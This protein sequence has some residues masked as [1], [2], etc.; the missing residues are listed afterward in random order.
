MTAIGADVAE[1]SLA[2]PDGRTLVLGWA[3][4]TDRGL[5]RAHNEDSVLAAVPYFAVADGMGGHA[6]GDVASDAVIRRLAEEQ[7]R[8][9]S[10]FADPEGVEPALDLAVGDIR[11]ETG[12]LEL[13]AGT[14]VT[15]ACLTLVSDRPYWAVFNVGDSRVYQLRGD[16]L[17]QVTVDHSVVQEMVDAGRITR[18]QADRHPDG[19]IITRAVGVGDAAEADYWLLPVT[20]RLRLLVCSDGLTKELADAEIRGHLLRADDAATAVRDLVVH[21]LEN[22]GRDNV[23]AVVVDV[24]RIDP[25]A[26]TPEPARRR[27]LRR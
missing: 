7:E 4:M 23:T 27:G 6:A 11:E 14:T 22:G 19:N 8:A 15:G 12:D 26:D 20:A 21:A 24:L 5:R 2:L 10:G 18:A 17:E 13:H 16:V 3:S 9:G 25:A 1:T